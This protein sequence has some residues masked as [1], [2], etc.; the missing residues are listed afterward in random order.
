PPTVRV[1][2]K[3]ADGM[4][5]LSCRAYGFYPRPIT[6]SWLKDGKIRDPETERGGIV[7][8]ADGTY[9]TWAS[10][11]AREAEKDKYRCR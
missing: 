4:L 1:S 8:N 9:Y 11:Q 2:G 6:V 7:P 10:I 5:T 3:K